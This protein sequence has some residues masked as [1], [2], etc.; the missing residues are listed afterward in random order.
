MDKSNP[1]YMSE[2]KNRS[3][4]EYIFKIRIHGFDGRTLWRKVSVKD[5]M[6]LCDLAV[7]ILDAFDFGIDHPFGF[8]EKAGFCYPG[9]GKSYELFADL[10]EEGLESTGS[11]SVKNTKVRDVWK[12]KGDVMHLLFDYGDEWWFAVRLEKL[13]D[14]TKGRYPRI[15][16]QKGDAP[17]QYPDYEEDED[18]DE[19]DTL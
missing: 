19:D 14:E 16:D 3:S 1:L 7:G 6:N 8:F 15:V 18:E 2:N 17:E 13:S 5:T 12:K 4:R 9:K 11:G 10:H